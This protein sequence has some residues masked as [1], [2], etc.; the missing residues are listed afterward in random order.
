MN[1]KLNHGD[2]VALI[3]LVGGKHEQLLGRYNAYQ[4]EFYGKRANGEPFL[5]QRGSAVRW[6]KVANDVQ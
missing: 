2:Q 5:V 3:V 1:E 6:E 4:D